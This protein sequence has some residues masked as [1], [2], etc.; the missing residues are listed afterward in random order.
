MEGLAWASF[1]ST[2]STLFSRDKTFSVGTTALGPSGCVY[3]SSSRI[4]PHGPVLLCQ[5]TKH[6]LSIPASKW[7]VLLV[8]WV[9]LN[10]LLQTVLCIWHHLISSWCLLHTSSF[11]EGSQA[12]SCLAGLILP[13]SLEQLCVDPYLF[14]RQSKRKLITR[15]GQDWLFWQTL[16][17]FNHSTKT[18]KNILYLCQNKKLRKFKMFIYFP[19]RSPSLSKVETFPSVREHKLGTICKQY[20]LVMLQWKSNITKL[21]FCN[22]IYWLWEIF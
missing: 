17:W 20:L 15:M 11:S 10:T 5:M 13:L 1:Q 7:T 2:R 19:N 16:C 18:E 3:F 8:F 21:T 12:G 9:L 14:A 22:A 4:G 6:M